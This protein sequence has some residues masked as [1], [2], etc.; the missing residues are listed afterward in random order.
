MAIITINNK[1]INRSDTASSGQRWTATSATASD[2]QAAAVAG[3]NT[4]A[5][6]AFATSTQ[7]SI[8]DNVLTKIV[9]EGEV[10]DTDSKYNTSNQRFTPT[11]AGKYYVYGMVYIES[12]SGN[13][14]NRADV[15][16]YKNG[17]TYKNSVSSY[18]VDDT[19][20]AITGTISAVMDLDDDDYVEFYARSNVFTGVSELDG[21]IPSGTF[22]AFRIIT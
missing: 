2:F 19:T 9:F 13:N 5:F 1:A 11:V 7:S 3:T 14:L 15:H 12:S 10:Y 17:S 6:E 4:P 16:I 8:G 18:T 21:R 22:G 20:Y